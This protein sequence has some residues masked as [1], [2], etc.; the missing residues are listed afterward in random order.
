MVPSSVS[1]FSS[2][3]SLR[4]F[5]LE[6]RDQIRRDAAGGRDAPV[7]ERKIEQELVGSGVAIGTDE[8][9]E[10][11]FVL[12]LV[13]AERHRADDLAGI[14]PNLRAMPGNGLEAFADA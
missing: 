10:A 1:R 4:Q 6:L 12:Q 13:R 14:A 7:A 9:G 2:H 11:A 3:R 5:R 8:V